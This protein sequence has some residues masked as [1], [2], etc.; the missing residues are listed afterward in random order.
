M[1][2][3]YGKVRPHAPEGCEERLTW[4]WLSKVA[5]YP[6]KEWKKRMQRYLDFLADHPHLHVVHV[7]SWREFMELQKQLG[8]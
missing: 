7:K 8:L 2:L 3:N 4:A 6:L 1:V 5:F